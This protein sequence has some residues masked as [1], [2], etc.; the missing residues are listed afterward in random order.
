[1]T[2]SEMRGGSM[3]ARAES[4]LC[5]YLGLLFLSGG[6]SHERLKKR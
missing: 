2:T 5:L 6:Q 3:K 4:A 1:V